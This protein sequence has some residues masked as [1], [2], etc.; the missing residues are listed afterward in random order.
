[1]QTLDDF[2]SFFR[3]ADLANTAGIALKAR[4][5]FFDGQQILGSHIFEDIGADIDVTQGNRLVH[6]EDAHRVVALFHT[7]HVRLKRRAEEIILFG[8]S[9]RAFQAADHFFCDCLRERFDEF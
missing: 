3:F 6:A 1:M 8:A 4:F 2:Q 7:A 5:Q 9:E